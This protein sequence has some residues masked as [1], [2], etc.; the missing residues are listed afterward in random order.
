MAYTKNT[1]YQK[2]SNMKYFIIVSLLYLVLSFNQSEGADLQE[3]EQKIFAA[4]KSMNLKRCLVQLGLLEKWSKEGQDEI[5]IDKDGSLGQMDYTF[6]AAKYK[7]VTQVTLTWSDGVKRDDGN[8][9]IITMIV[10]SDNSYYY[11]YQLID[12]KYHQSETRKIK[13]EDEGGQ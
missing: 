11:I 5:L 7:D 9:R 4:D 3:L 12:G 8:E 10:F 13:T 1:K 2:L 6:S